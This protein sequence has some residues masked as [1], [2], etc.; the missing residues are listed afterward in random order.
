MKRT[1]VLYIEDEPALGRIV[2]ES[3]ESR[4]FSVSMGTDGGEAIASFLRNKPDICVLDIMLPEKDGYTIAREIRRISPTVPIIFL[5]AKTQTEDLLKGFESGGNDYIHKPFSME[6]LIV[7]ISNLLQLT[8][9]LSSPSPEIIPLGQYTFFPL[10]Y[11]LQNGADTRKLSYREANLLMIFMENRNA[12]VKR[13]DILLR[14]WGDDSFFNS[15]TLD[16]YITKLREYLRKDPSIEIITVKGVGY[17]F[18]A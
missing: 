4:D 12:L 16:V 5:T 10:R 14:I 1:K 15:R 2:K 18:V 13:K 9:G 7:R 3:L 11:E 8:S 17:H 6:E